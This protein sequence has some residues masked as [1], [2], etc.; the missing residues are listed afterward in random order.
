MMRIA[1]FA[2]LCAEMLTVGASAQGRMG[3]CLKSDMIFICRIGM[4]DFYP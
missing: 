4:G 3:R 1:R 2:I